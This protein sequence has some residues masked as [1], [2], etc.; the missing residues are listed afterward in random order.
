MDDGRWTMDDGRWT[1]DDAWR[2]PLVD[3]QS[4]C[5]PENLDRQQAADLFFILARPATLLD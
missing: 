1:M 4:H 5:P 2:T 3:V